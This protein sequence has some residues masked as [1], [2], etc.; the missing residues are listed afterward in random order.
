MKFPLIVK[1]VGII[2]IC[3]K[4]QGFI[5][6]I[7]LSYKMFLADNLLPRSW[8]FLFNLKIKISEKEK[9]TKSSNCILQSSR[10]YNESI[11]YIY[12]TIWKP[13]VKTIK[14]TWFTRP[15]KTRNKK[16]TRVGNPLCMNFSCFRY[17]LG[18]T[19]AVLPITTFKEA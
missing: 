3:I 14:F 8:H 17:F 13:I 4:F 16:F 10:E 18:P 1:I 15:R 12:D 9:L 5:S 19:S 7:W 11:F 6:S 2:L